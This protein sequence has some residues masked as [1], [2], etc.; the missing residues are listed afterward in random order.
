VFLSKRIS[1]PIKACAERLSL[2]SHGDLTSSVSS[3]KSKDETSIL[4]NS[5]KTTIN[6]ISSAIEDVSFHLGQ[7]ENGILSDE[8]TNEYEGDFAKLKASTQGIV[9]Y[10]NRDLTFINEA[11]MQ[12]SYGSDQVAAGAQA[13]SQGTTEQA[14]S[15]EELSATLNE[16]SKDV[17]NNA[18]NSLFVRQ[19]TENLKNE[20]LRSNQMMHELIEAMSQISNTSNKI[21]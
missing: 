12:V 3:A 18:R 10:L 17:N 19:R 11:S 16:I 21:N 2:L 1:D 4:L 9:E 8:V 15:V 20:I 13:L 14:G 7:I 6:N 5:L